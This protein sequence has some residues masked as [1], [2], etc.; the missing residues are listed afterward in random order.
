MRK[1]EN[2]ARLVDGTFAGPSL[3]M[4]QAF[5]NLVVIGFTIE[6]ALPRTSTMAADYLGPA[7]RGRIV[8]RR[9]RRCPRSGRRARTGFG[10]RAG[11]ATCVAVNLGAGPE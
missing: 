5:R 1:C 7:D 4:I 2:G 6:E 10:H 8:H 9:D 11:S 3:T